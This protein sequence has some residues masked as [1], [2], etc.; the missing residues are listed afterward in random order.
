[1]TVRWCA[2]LNTLHTTELYTKWVNCKVCGLYFNKA[3]TKKHPSTKTKKP[4]Q[5]CR[6]PPWLLVKTN[7]QS[8]QL[9]PFPLGTAPQFSLCCPVKR[10]YFPVSLTARCGHV[11]S[12]SQRDVI[13]SIAG[14]SRKSFLK[15]SS[16]PVLTPT[17]PYCCLNLQPGQLCKQPR[18]GIG[19]IK[20]RWSLDPRG[21]GEPAC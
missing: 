8:P 5:T 17:S 4:N 14:T 3:V 15:S 10:L 16:L 13:N 7:S 18:S 6:L 19:G 2:T 12:S 1:M 9:P 20:G 11:Q 21:S